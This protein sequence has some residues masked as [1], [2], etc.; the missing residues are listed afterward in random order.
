MEQTGCLTDSELKQIREDSKLHINQI[1]IERVK[2]TLKRIKESQKLNCYITAEDAEA[3]SNFFCLTQE[4][5][6]EMK[7]DT[8]KLPDTLTKKRIEYILERIQESKENGCEIST[9]DFEVFKKFVFLLQVQLTL[10]NNQCFPAQVFNDLIL[11][12]T[13]QTGRFTDP[14][15]YFLIR[16]IEKNNAIDKRNDCKLSKDQKQYYSNLLTSLKLE[17][18]RRLAKGVP[19]RI[20]EETRLDLLS[21]EANIVSQLNQSRNSL[22]NITMNQLS[23]NVSKTL[24]GIMDDIL[25][26]EKNK[27]IMEVWIEAFTKESRP[28]YIGI[29]LII[30]S[31][32]IGLLKNVA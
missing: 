27:N 10:L 11:Y 18:E 4:E 13:E 23:I 9:I 30:L 16:S 20:D 31:I 8:Y 5:I 1:P 29:F 2:S 7:A 12:A 28:I 6:D 24:L 17:R 22:P 25:E 26:P 19:K 21:E 3:V 15:L 32:F 14:E